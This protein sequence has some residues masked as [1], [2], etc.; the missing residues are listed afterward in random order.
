M[1]SE[2]PPTRGIASLLQRWEEGDREALT[3]RAELQFRVVGANPYRP[4]K[5]NR[6]RSDF[7]VPDHR[8][9][10]EDASARRSSPRERCLLPESNPGTA[11]SGS[12]LMFISRPI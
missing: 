1:P 9:V 10:H 5:A 3:S 4:F 2:N 11:D 6:C 12:G 8:M 7:T